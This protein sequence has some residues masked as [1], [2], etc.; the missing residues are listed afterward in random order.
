MGAA[1][2]RLQRRGMVRLDANRLVLTDEGRAAASQLVRSHRLWESYLARHIAVPA[3]HLHDTAM[4][5]EHITGSAMQEQL[6]K[7]V[8]DPDKDP[9][10][11]SIPAADHDPEN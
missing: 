11:T 7:A 3:D 9:H 5:L 1:L 4:A 6:A 2:R 8:G 10:G